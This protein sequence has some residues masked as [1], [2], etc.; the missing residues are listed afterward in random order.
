MINLLKACAVVLL[1]AT[2][3][4]AQQINPV[5]AGKTWNRYT[6]DRFVI[7]SLDQKQG[8]FLQ[9][10]L[11]KIK[12]WSI[13][14]WGMPDYSY[15]T[16]CRI[17]VVNDKELMRKLF[18]LSDTHTE[19][20]DNMRVVWLLSE[21]N[22]VETMSAALVRFSLDDIEREHHIKFG[23]WVY[24]G[25]GVLNMPIPQIRAHFSL[26]SGKMVNDDKMFFSK[27]LFSIDRVKYNRYDETTKQLFDAEAAAVCLLLRKEFGQKN[28][29]KV[30]LTG[31]SEDNLRVILGFQNYNKFDVTFRRYM[32]NLS[33]DIINNKTPD[34][35][36]EIA[37][38]YQP[39][40]TRR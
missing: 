23:M 28:F 31:A 24:R 17:Q 1:A 15:P 37:P 6:V 33:S 10:N 14:R 4:E 12:Q 32:I 26:L 35:Y 18:G 40:N 7:L 27:T 29:H 5:I 36:L 2:P 13:N 19:V 20:Q 30:A 3:L 9:K 38:A 34:S 8:V 11:S 39:M 22:P 16:E 25:M 21:G